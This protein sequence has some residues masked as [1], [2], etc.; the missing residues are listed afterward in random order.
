MDKKD[1]IKIYGINPEKIG[2]RKRCWFVVDEIEIEEKCVGARIGDLCIRTRDGGYNPIDKEALKIENF[3]GT[4]V[5]RFDITY[6]Y[7]YYRKK[8]KSK[9]K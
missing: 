4:S 1:V 6:R 5:S 9:K 2:K 8:N 7:Y 3:I